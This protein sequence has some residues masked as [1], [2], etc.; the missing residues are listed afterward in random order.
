MRK[1]ILPLLVLLIVSF[2][3]VYYLNPYVESMDM[4]KKTLARKA[5]KE[6]E[7][8]ARKYQQFLML[9]DPATGLIPKGIYAMEREFMNSF[10]IRMLKRSELNWVERGPNNTGGRVRS[11]AIDI[12]T[13]TIPN[14]T[15]ITGGI[16][17]G[18]W[19]ST[20]NGDT[21]MKT[22]NTSSLHSVTSIVQD[23]RAG[24]QNTWYAGT[25]ENIGN[26]ADGGGGALYLGDGLFKSTDNGNSWTPIASTQVNNPT[27]WTSDWQ[28]VWRLAIDQNNTAQDVV[29]AATTGGVYRSQNGGNDWTKI[30]A[31][32]TS[33]AVPMD[34]TT[35]NNGTVYAAAG[36]KG[37][38]ENQIKGIRKSTDGGNSFQDITPADMPENYG[39]IVF[40]VAPS[41]QDVLYF[42][43]EGVSGNNSTTAA[44]GHQ[45]WRSP[46]AGST[47]TNISSVI[48]SN[49]AP[50]LDNFSTQNGYDMILNVKP[51]NPNF[52]IFGGVSL[53]KVHDVTNDNMT[54]AEKHIGGYGMSTNGTA[55]ALNDFI[56][57]HPDQHIGVF[58]PGNSKVFYCGNDGS[59]NITDDIT[60]TTELNK[61]WLQPKRTGLNIT[62]FYSIAIAPE[63]GSGFLA[64]GLQDR[65]NWMARTS[66]SLQSWQEVSGGDGTIA[67]ITPD[68]LN[69]VFQAT[70]EGNIFRYPKTDTSSPVGAAIPM[71]PDGVANVLFVNPFILDPNDG[72]LLYFS[73]GTNANNSGI[74][75]NTKATTATNTEGWQ[76]LT[77]SEAPNTQVTAIAASTTNSQ[78]VL[79]YGTADGKVFRIDNANT[80][81]PNKLDITGANFPQGYVNCIAVDPTNSANAI[82]VFSNYNVDRL[83]Y[84]TDSG[85]TWTSISGNLNGASSPSVR[86]AELFYV[87]NQ[88]NVY[89]ATSA[90]LF[91][92][93]T[94]SGTTTN[95]LPEAQS[96][97][98]NVVCVMLDFRSS[99]NTLV[100]ATHG[101][102]AFEA[103]ITSTATAPASPSKLTASA[104]NASSIKLT[105]QDNSSDETGFKIERKTN[106]S[107]SWSNLVSLDPNVTSHTDNNLTD[108]VKY[109]Y[110]IY[111]INA[112]GNST[113]SNE[114]NAVTIMNA[115][116]NLSV[117]PTANSR[118]QL[119]WD[120]NSHS[121]DGY[122]VERKIGQNGNFQ[123]LKDV[124]ANTT[125]LEDDAVNPGQVYYYRVKGYNNNLSS[126][127]SNEAVVTITD[128]AGGS[129]IP[130]VFELY[131]NYPNPFNPST[132][133]KFAIPKE[134]K[135]QLRIYDINGQLVSTLM[136]EVKS[137]GYYSINWSG[138]D[139]YG[140]SISSGI[141]LYVIDAV[142]FRATK[143][144]LFLK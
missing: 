18:I 102:G 122:T 37:G 25:G 97:I 32:G 3:V 69:T 38:A 30:L 77:N 8:A 36:S 95:W 104:E 86:W 33:Q 60:K 136:N 127:Y 113:F 105:W 139:N 11:L 143:K 2:S 15:I 89:L 50:D 134:S 74:W 103:K 10:P 61:F 45:L 76:F 39:R 110:R 52:V 13:T 1:R 27:S 35:T 109:Y 64:G 115:P 31:A 120:D 90:G 12:R 124:N 116:T 29:Y 17:G 55:N 125:V 56:N 114:E 19:K 23:T 44:H 119:K 48:P 51:D 91:S 7:N 126:A 43:V 118:A 53:F 111:A 16:S 133:I 142:D 117:Q 93:H 128:I 66:G 92:T 47:W 21:W 24:K 123:K 141:Y 20:N 40:A 67:Q 112:V 98:G 5:Q 22:T 85:T 59:V 80:G 107:D 137:P 135:V 49:T 65:G 54:L 84:T 88:L 6:H 81:D 41:N 96:S 72:N 82:V 144:M 9:R 83:W 26:S 130:T 68:A 129:S 132:T 42:L 87:N 34:I 58:L 63:A 100:V 138:L 62:Q 73:G 46:D 4:M 70:T 94:L 79:Y 78:N 101:R 108:G 14:V 99:D 106:P 57:H 131:Q 75:R 140:K 28:Y 71:K 121:E